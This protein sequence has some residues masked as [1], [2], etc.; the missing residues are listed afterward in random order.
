[1][2]AILFALLMIVYAA[3]GYFLM[4]RLDRFLNNHVTPEDSEAC[5]DRQ[6]GK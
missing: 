5:S 1:M 2:G 4:D 3:G 6:H